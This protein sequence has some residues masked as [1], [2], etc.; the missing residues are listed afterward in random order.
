V[1][2]RDLPSFDCYRTLGVP[3]TATVDEIEAAFRAAAKREHPDLHEDAAAAT[4]RM[5]RLNV[6]R[7]WLTDPIRRARY[8]AARGV[9]PVGVAATGGLVFDP[10]DVDA[11]GSWQSDAL[12]EQRGSHAGPVMASIALMVLITMVFVGSTSL[13]AAAIA[14][15]AMVVLVIGAALTIRG[16][17][18]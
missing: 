4:L 3:A 8:D 7:D 1:P 18:G 2:D 16:A 12:P 13:L 11:F 6:A 5:Q 17:G 14:V 15:A 9:G 10:S